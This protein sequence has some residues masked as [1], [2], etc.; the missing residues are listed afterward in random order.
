MQSHIMRYYEHGSIDI[1]TT[2]D[3]RTLTSNGTP[4]ATTEDDVPFPVI[5]FC[6]NSPHSRI[7]RNYTF[8]QFNNPLF[9]PH[10]SK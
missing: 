6:T 4:D 2:V 7:K 5:V 9:Y 1:I 10:L 8:I 3:H